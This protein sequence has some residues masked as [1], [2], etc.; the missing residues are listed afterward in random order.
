VGIVRQIVRRFPSGLDRLPH[1]A[2]GVPELD[3]DPAWRVAAAYLVG[4]RGHTRKAY[5]NDIKAWYAWCNE[6]GVA[7]LEAQRHHV[8]RWIAGLMEQPQPR[9]GKPAAVSTIA[10]RLS[11]LTGLYEYAVVDVGVIDSSPIMRVKR[12]RVSEHSTTVGLD[13]KELIKLLAAAEADG[14]RSAA[15]ITLLALNGLRV[16][17]ALSRDVEHLTHNFGHRV[18]DLTRKGNKGSTEALAP[19]TSRVLDAYIGDRRSGPI[20]LN[21]DGKRLSEPSAWRLVRRLARAAGLPAADRLSPHSLRHSAITAALNAGVPFRDV[22]DFA[23][24]A[25]PRTTRRYDRSRNSLDRHA[26]YAL[27]ARLGRGSLGD[28]PSQGRS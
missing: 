28:Q 5:F 13:E 23:G 8:D 6:A 20:F 4:F 19:A 12:P 21:R 15:L 10:R 17:E 9:T 18:L 27:A 24:H 22:Q 7:P 16:G 1:Q 14:L 11:C 2:L 26:T 3:A 25:D